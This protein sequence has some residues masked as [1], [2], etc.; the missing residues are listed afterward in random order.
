MKTW[1]V[2]IPPAG[3]MNQENATIS[4]Q[5]HIYL[6]AGECHKQLLSLQTACAIPTPL[7]KS[8]E[9]WHPPKSSGDEAEPADIFV[10]L[11]KTKL[12]DQ[13]L[14]AIKGGGEIWLQ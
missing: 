2:K 12:L 8:W 13:T 5:K 3:S 11:E 6:W 4:E 10:G 9:D 7:W 14:K 1:L